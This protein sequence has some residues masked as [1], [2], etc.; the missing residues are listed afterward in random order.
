MADDDRDLFSPK[1][2]NPESS[3][4]VELLIALGVSLGLAIAGGLILGALMC[5]MGCAR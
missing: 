3:P 1:P 5:H 2:L 4:T